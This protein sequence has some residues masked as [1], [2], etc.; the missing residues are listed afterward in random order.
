MISGGSAGDSI[1][2]RHSSGSDAPKKNSNVTSI[3]KTRS[4][5]KAR[6]GDSSPHSGRAP[7][8]RSGYRSI[9]ASVI[10]PPSEWPVMKVESGSP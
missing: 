2:G 4:L 9:E 3:S 6:E 8:Y 1:T 7:L 10:I 5:K